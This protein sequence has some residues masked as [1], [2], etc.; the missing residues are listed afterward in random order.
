MCL[1]TKKE[2]VKMSD[3]ILPVPS[4]VARVTWTA[5][6][7]RVVEYFFDLDTNEKVILKCSRICESGVVHRIEWFAIKDVE[8]VSSQDYKGEY[9]FDDEVGDINYAGG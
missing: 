4:K 2:P 8:L 6:N 9:N 7:K 5:F 1:E 3:N